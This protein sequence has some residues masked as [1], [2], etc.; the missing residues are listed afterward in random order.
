MK[1]IISLSIL[2]VIL[3]VGIVSATSY[4]VNQSGGNTA[5]AGTSPTIA[6]KNCSDISSRSFAKGDIISI[7]CGQ[8]GTENKYRE[9]LGIYGKQ[10]ITI[11][12]YGNCNGTNDP[13]LRG[14]DNC[15]ISWCWT[16]LNMPAGLWKLNATTLTLRTSPNYIIINSSKIAK[17]INRTYTL[18][19]QLTTQWDWLYNATDKTI[20]M[21]SYAD[22]YTIT[23]DIEIPDIV[24]GGDYGTPVLTVLGTSGNITFDGLDVWMGNNINVMLADDN[25]D[26]YNITWKNSWEDFS[27]EKTFYAG[28]QVLGINLTDNRIGTH[29]GLKGVYG[30]GQGEGIFFGSDPMVSITRNNITGNGGV[31]INGFV[32]KNTLIQGNRIVCDKSILGVAVPAGIYCERCNY[33]NVTNNYVANCPRA[34]EENTEAP[35]EGN[36]SVG[37]SFTYNIAWNNCHDF[38]VDANAGYW[39]NASRNLTVSHNTFIDNESCARSISGL[40]NQSFY[41]TNSTGLNFSDNLFVNLNA[42]ENKQIGSFRFP[43]IVNYK[44]RNN[45]YDS[46]SYIWDLG[47]S[48]SKNTFA[49]YQAV[50]GEVGSYTGSSN[51][52]LTTFKPSGQACISSTTGSYVGA[53]AC[54]SSS[55]TLY[56]NNSNSNCDNTHTRIEASNPLTPWCNAKGAFITG[57]IQGGDTVIFSPGTYNNATEIDWYT[58]TLTAP[59]TIDCMGSNITSY[60]DKFAVVENNQWRNI[61]LLVG[62]AN[63]WNASVGSVLGTNY[64]KVYFPNESAFYLTEAWDDNSPNSDASMLTGEHTSFQDRPTYNRVWANDTTNEIRIKL[65]SG[66]N[67]SKIA[68]YVAADYGSWRIRDNNGSVNITIQNCNFKFHRRGLDLTNDSG[69]V[70]FNNTFAEGQASILIR[71]GNRGNT[72][73]KNNV[74]KGGH[75]SEYLQQFSKNSYEESDLITTDNDPNAPIYVYNNTFNCTVGGIGIWTNS[76][77][78][79]CGTEVAY[80]LFNNW[81]CGQNSQMEIEAYNCNSSWHDNRIYGGRLSGI[82]LGG[83][84]CSTYNCKLYNNLV[85]LDAWEIFNETIS[86]ETYALKAYWGNNVKVVGWNISHNTFIAKGRGWYGVGDAVN[87]TYNTTVRDNIF[88]GNSSGASSVIYKTGTS[89]DGNLWDYNL[90]FKTDSPVDLFNYWQNNT[91]AISFSSLSLAL[92]SGK[93]AGGW[94]IHSNETNPNLNLFYIP[95]GKACSM[96]STGSYVGAFA[97]TYFGTIL[98]DSRVWQGASTTN[99]GTA[100]TMTI[101]DFTTDGQRDYVM[102]DLSGVSNS[103]TTI[104]ANL[105][106]YLNGTGQNLNI[107]SYWVYSNVSWDENIITWD[108]QPCLNFTTASGNC[109]NVSL[110]TV[111]TTTSDLWYTWDISSAV[112][113]EVRKGSRNITIM[114]RTNETGATLADT[115]HTKENGNNQPLFNVSWNNVSA[116]CEGNLS[117]GLNCNV[118]QSTTLSGANFTVYDTTGLGAIQILSGN[119]NI[120]FDCNGSTFFGNNSNPSR[121]FY[122]AFFLKNITIRNC[123][124]FNYH[125]GIY[126]SYLN[127]SVIAN[128]TFQNMT[129]FIALVNTR[130]ITLTNNKLSYNNSLSASTYGI[131]AWTTN[132]N[133]NYGYLNISNNLISSM[134][135]GISIKGNDTLNLIA[136]NNITNTVGTGYGIGLK[137]NASLTEVKNNRLVNMSR[138]G[139]S[140]GNSDQLGINNFGHIIHDN[141]IETYGHH[142]IGTGDLTIPFTQEFNLRIYNNYIIQISQS[143]DIGSA[144][145]FVSDTIN[146]TITNNTIVNITGTGLDNEGGNFSNT[147]YFINNS[148]LNIKGRCFESQ[149]NDTHYLGNNFSNCTGGTGRILSP[150]ANTTM[151]AYLIG[152]FYSDIPVNIQHYY[153]RTTTIINESTTQ[154]LYLNF[155]F[156]PANF[157]FSFSGRK[158]LTIVNNTITANQGSNGYSVYNITKG[159][160]TYQNVP[161]FNLTVNANEQYNVTTTC[162]IPYDGLTYSNAGVYTLCQGEYN[163]PD[164]AGDGAII[165]NTNN[166]W[167]YGYNVSL[168]GTANYSYK[169][170]GIYTGVRSNTT[171]VGFTISNYSYG[172]SGR[173]LSNNISNNYFYNNVNQSIRSEQQGNNSDISYNFIYLADN[174]LDV[175]YS[176]I[177]DLE[178]RYNRIY[179]NNVTGGYFQI[180]TY[181]SNYTSIYN[182]YAFN[183]TQ[184]NI[185]VDRGVSNLIYDNFV[186]YAIH[187]NID[188]QSQDSMAYN[189]NA[190][191]AGH[192]AMDI[193]GGISQYTFNISYFNNRLTNSCTGI[194]IFAANNSKIYNNYIYGMNFSYS[195]CDRTQGDTVSFGISAAGNGTIGANTQIYG[196]YIELITGNLSIDACIFIQ[197]NNFSVYNNTLR[198]CGRT[199]IAIQNYQTTDYA[200]GGIFN[201][202]YI[203]NFA[204][205]W[206]GRDN[207]TR[208]INVTITESTTSYSLINLSNNATLYLNFNGLKNFKILNYS[209]SLFNLTDQGFPVVNIYNGS[210]LLYSGT[211]NEYN[212]SLNGLET[213]TVSYPVPITSPSGL[214]GA[215]FDTGAIPS[216]TPTPTPTVSPTPVR[217]GLFNTTRIDQLQQVFNSTRI[218]EL[219]S[220]L[221]NNIKRYSDNSGIRK[222]YDLVIVNLGIFFSNK[223]NLF[224]TIGAVLVSITLLASIPAIK[225]RRQIK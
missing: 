143:T 189:N 74:F 133:T 80:N 203:D 169:Q 195:F 26:V 152:N 162:V 191:R 73:I 184:N 9:A 50:V 96:S 154:N 200:I 21:N 36:N 165:V 136:Y 82:S 45:F 181:F 214:V 108:N 126:A 190:S 220:K 176:G 113:S 67:A 141:Y 102:L 37:N 157:T 170:K 221:G 142:A 85:V 123:N 81:G 44:F 107:S 205:Y 167:L 10:N 65:A 172:I 88:V 39:R 100:T 62:L 119:S 12:R 94:D 204:Y 121:I 134:Y 57:N 155:T 14:A 51:I 185:Y 199:S 35:G 166:V 198:N 48:G 63:V 208:K 207:P 125:Y 210:T 218:A 101:R 32:Q 115:F 16:N 128:N 111:A 194:F 99:Y 60:V 61:S 90:Y 71:T 27:W 146:A 6:W 78:D 53:V 103:S 40:Y 87:E 46:N 31:N 173:F 177:Q 64:P 201:N 55:V 49:A 182:N 23:S 22:P 215:A 2:F 72:Y 140:R 76:P 150:D 206:I 151:T 202:S 187:N 42:S 160:Y 138:N 11:T 112:T 56:V 149:S 137:E 120:V 54:D 13:Q 89:F 161:S 158:D 109:S 70:L 129:E 163:I 77:Y 95:S 223:T 180:Y 213:Y 104:K 222:Y 211:Q 34:Y 127:D 225:R 219:A 91:N 117:L 209:I 139:I 135:A 79:A 17:V 217:P 192:H 193:Y 106:L 132:S 116:T 110:S 8:P 147:I 197:P 196:N 20:T 122:L 5:N 84:N 75:G 124:G 98:D 92:A 93:N 171:I 130:N 212:L 174:R 168:T 41:I 52:N 156:Y 1:K 19:S 18:P 7:A 3:A 114:F 224:I 43:N 97:C 188:V 28:S 179:N 86:Y 144:A 4:Y 183:A 148:L 58:N 105:S 145:I 33:T 68:L 178:T 25:P 175:W 66:Q 216:V 15:S 164:I 69:I 83:A 29:A 24:R 186:D 118:N 30:T 47:S 153:N 38:T 59:V 131:E 159:A